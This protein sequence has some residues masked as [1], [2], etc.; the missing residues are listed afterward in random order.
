MEACSKGEAECRRV[1]ASF[2]EEQCRKI[3]GEKCRSPRA[4]RSRYY[5][6][7]ERILVEGVPDGRRRL[8]LYVISRYLLNVKGLAVEEA[9]QVIDGF[10]EESC[11]KYGD[12]SKIYK[13]WVRSVLR[14][15]KQGGWKP[16][17]L[18]RMRRED[19]ELYDII[20]RTMGLQER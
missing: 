12:C 5:D 4:A 2:M 17:S 11:R 10:I 6:W 15:V 8:I 9:E 20:S 1:L 16:W 18:E 3:L 7:I 13:S 19:P 14:S